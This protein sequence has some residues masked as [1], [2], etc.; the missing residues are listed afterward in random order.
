VISRTGSDGVGALP[1]PSGDQ[2]Q[3]QLPDLVYPVKGETEELRYS[4][5]SVAE[6]ARGL[7]GRVWLVGHRPAWAVNVEHIDVAVP[8]GKAKDVPAK[9]RAVC[10]H[11]DVAPTFVLMNDDYY[12]LDPV[13]RWEAWHM[14]AIADRIAFW[15]REGKGAA[16]LRMVEQ[17]AAWVA[18][19]GGSGLCWQGHRPLLWDKAKLLDV[20]DRYPE[21]RPLDVIGLFD[22]AGADCG[23]P[24]RGFN[25]KVT[26]D[27]GMF[28]RKLAAFAGSPCPWLSSNDQ[29]FQTGMI[30]GFI[31]GVFRR[32]CEYEREV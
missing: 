16:W 2:A 23:E 30:G 10:E 28:H 12:L 11:P 21:G 3:Q 24:R 8:G 13:E 32:P 15:R 14:G 7:F 5:R 31:R 25:T 4:L 9:L 18:E 26:S 29:A 22:L 20:L 1:T 19:Q 6:N 17:T 27:P